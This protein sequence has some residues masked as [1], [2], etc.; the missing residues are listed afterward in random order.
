MNCTLALEL[1]LDAEPA[2]LSLAAESPLVAHLRSCDKCRAVAARLHA[3]TIRL[4]DEV[5]A[6]RALSAPRVAKPTRWQRVA[7]VAAAAV[8]IVTFTTRIASRSEAPAVAGN[9]R[10]A[11]V[12]AE[13]AAPA[14]TA[15]PALPLAQSTARATPQPS[16]AGLVQVVAE[17]QRSV[18]A[19]AEVASAGSRSQNAGDTRGIS[20]VPPPG[21]RAMVFVTR[22]PGITIVWLQ[23]DDSLRTPR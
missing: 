14:A 11:A 15:V 10:P 2:E 21:M 16:V 3:E 12:T 22:D 1:L 8:I 20:V 13:P 17:P 9:P 23:A 4:A 5:F 6:R 7:G 18:T 19:S